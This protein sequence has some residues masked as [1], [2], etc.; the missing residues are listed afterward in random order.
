MDRHRRE[1]HSG[2]FTFVVDRQLRE[3]GG[4]CHR[5]DADH[6]ELGRVV[7]GELGREQRGV[8]ALRVPEDRDLGVVLVLHEL[9]GGAHAVEHGAAF[10]LTDE[11]RV[12]TATVAPQARV[13]GRGDDRAGGD[14]LIQL[15]DA[16]RVPRVFHRGRALRRD[17]AGAVRPRHDRRVRRG[18]AV[19][20]DDDPGHRDRL[21]ARPRGRVED[22]EG[23]RPGD[24][25]AGERLGPDE[26][27]GRSIGQRLRRVV[28]RARVARVDE[29]IRET[30]DAHDQRD[31]ADNGDDPCPLVGPPVVSR[32][33]FRS[34]LVRC[35]G[36]PYP[37]SDEPS[38]VPADERARRLRSRVRPVARGMRRRRTR[39]RRGSRARGAP[40]ARPRAVGCTDRHG[41]GAR[42]GEPFLRPLP[43]MARER[44]RVPRRRPRQVRAQL[45]RQRPPARA[46]HGR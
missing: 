35:S 13:V 38:E 18:L 46:L 8:T 43:R 16:L 24:V 15:R 7:G 4:R 30:P 37:L 12:R 34:C 25:R 33:E 45:P 22:A 23:L 11:V 32:H 1:D 28:E 20:D 17:T 44:Y 6:V 21:V 29:P 39:P 41:R 26:R 2:R 5:R 36:E 27:A 40:P 31:R 3:I 14:E 19:R 42:H 9:L 10:A